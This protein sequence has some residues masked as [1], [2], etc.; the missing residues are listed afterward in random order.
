MGKKQL[1]FMLI[2]FLVVS[3]LVACDDSSDSGTSNVNS[4]ETVEDINE[5]EDE[6]LS[7]I[8]AIADYEDHDDLEDYT[9]DSSEIILI[10]LEGSSITIAGEGATIDGSTIVITSAGT[11]SIS[12][13]LDDGQIIVDTE[14][15]EIVRLILNSVVISSSTSAPIHVM[16]AEKTMIV[17]ADNTENYITDGESYADEEEANAAIYSED[18]LTIY[19]EG[20]LIVEGQFADG[21][22]SK[23]GLI[24][25]SG[26]INISAEDDGI[27]GKDYLVV[28]GGNITVT[29]SG[30]G[31]KSDNDE[32]SSKGYI[33]IED[34]TLKITSDGDAIQAETDVLIAGGEIELSSGGGSNNIIDESTSAKGIKAAAYITIDNG[35]I[36]ID[37]AD[38]AIHSNGS[39][40]INNGDITLA[41][42]DD[43]IHAD[44]DLI[45]N[46]GTIDITDSYEGI[47][48]AGGDIT[49][50]NGEIHIVSSDD[51]LNLA[52]SDNYLYINGGYI[53]IDSTGDGID[54]NGSIIMT[55]GVVVVNGPSASNNSALDYDGSFKMNYGF[56]VASGS[57]RMA[58]APG[59]SSSQ[60]SILLNFNS[61]LQADTLVHIETSDGEDVLTFAP[62]NSY[63]SIA[64]SSTELENGETYNVYYGGSSTGTVTDGLY[65]GGTYTSGTKYTDFTISSI[66]TTVN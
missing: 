15:E 10:A 31:L 39:L 42:G 55:D 64:F 2:F 17:L 43:A 41:S 48:S 4:T 7:D 45:I 52:D 32:D 36:D 54:A 20:S 19:G 46:D 24:I 66:V 18:D 16:N 22:T 25:T 13:N 28:K 27:R 40:T 62:T 9:W 12:G 37:A 11:F 29:A 6:D 8:A 34:G 51:G 63:Q 61:T 53:A 26:T 50:D 59:T 21:I 44:Y 23:D 49:I 58:E 3:L 35:T 47:E 56:L 1:L 14:D 57:S 33:S 5:V 65:E 38:D 30:D 60:Y